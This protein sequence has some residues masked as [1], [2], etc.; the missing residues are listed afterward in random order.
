[1]PGSLGN[2]EGVSSPL[3]THF[4]WNSELSCG[5][6]KE[7]GDTQVE[8]EEGKA[9]EAFGTVNFSHLMQEEVVFLTYCQF[10]R[11]QQVT[12]CP[13]PNLGSQARTPALRNME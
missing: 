7:G 8:V 2:I 13:S 10:S 1:M 3:P 11:N 9:H 5:Y 12:V 4:F 6:F